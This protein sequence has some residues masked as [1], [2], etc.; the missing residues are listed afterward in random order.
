METIF[1]FISNGDD[2]DSIKK[3]WAKLLSVTLKDDSILGFEESFFANENLVDQ[4]TEQIKSEIN[5]SELVLLI[6]TYQSEIIV[7]CTLKLNKQQTTSHICD[8]QKGLIHPEYRSKGLLEKSLAHIA[9]YCI[10]QNIELLTLDVRTNSVGYKVWIKS[11]FYTYGELDDYCRFN[12]KSY[13]GCFM[14]QPTK[15]LLEKFNSHIL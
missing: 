5:R 14:K 10:K 13:S 6:A 1:K 4:Y 2:F 9:S 7:C 3:S 15:A 12:G 8:L 11:G